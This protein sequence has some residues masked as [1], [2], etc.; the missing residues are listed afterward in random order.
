MPARPFDAQ[1]LQIG[2]L[3]EDAAASHLEAKGLR[4]LERNVCLG[5]LELDLVCEQG[6][7]LVFVEV[8]TRAEGSLATPADGLTAQKRSRLLR[9][10]QSYL[11]RHGLWHKPCRFDLVS[12]LV[13]ANAVQHIEH[14]ENAITADEPRPSKTRGWQPW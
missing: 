4:V 6:D 10:A 14:V 2:R 13:R 12:V 3:G 7:T 5:R 9:A 1:H 8:K 11:S